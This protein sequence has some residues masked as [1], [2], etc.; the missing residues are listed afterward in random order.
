MNTTGTNTNGRSLATPPPLPATKKDLLAQRVGQ[1]R[2]T[3]NDMV[4]ESHIALYGDDRYV[5]FLN[6]VY[7]EQAVEGSL[8]A[9]NIMAA[10]MI[11]DHAKKNG[12]GQLVNE[13]LA[14]ISKA[15]G[16][17]M[18]RYEISRKERRDMIHGETVPGNNGD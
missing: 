17:V 15:L 8:S 6:A 1:M 13:K 18:R 3:L 16:V 12:G 11:R 14:T 4:E 9:D 7:D 10:T 2:R 5:A